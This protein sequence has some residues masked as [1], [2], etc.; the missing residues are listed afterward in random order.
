MVAN[1]ILGASKKAWDLRAE[2]P[3][4]EMFRGRDFFRTCKGLVGVSSP[5]VKGI[6]AGDHIII[7]DGLSFP[8]VARRMVARG[9]HTYSIIGCATVRGVK[10]GQTCEDTVLPEGWMKEPKQLF[11]FE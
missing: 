8:L 6:K 9:N 1:R 2:D 10:P 7:I 5:G 11:M 4:A 3:A